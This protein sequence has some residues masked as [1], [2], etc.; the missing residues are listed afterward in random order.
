MFYK[1]IKRKQW[2]LIS[3]VF[4]LAV[5]ILSVDKSWRQEGNRNPY[6]TYSISNPVPLTQSSTEYWTKFLF[7]QQME[8]YDPNV[9]SQLILPAK[10]EFSTSTPQRRLAKV[11]IPGK[12]DALS[13]FCNWENS[14]S[15]LRTTETAVYDSHQAISR[16]SIELTRIEEAM[17]QPMFNN[18]VAVK[19]TG[20]KMM[21]NRRRRTSSVEGVYKRSAKNA[22]QTNRREKRIDAFSRCRKLIDEEQKSVQIKSNDATFVIDDESESETE[23]LDQ[24]YIERCELDA[25]QK[26]IDRMEISSLINLGDDFPINENDENTN[27]EQLCNTKMSEHPYEEANSKV[28]TME[29]QEN[30]SSNASDSVET[31]SSKFA[32]EENN[33]NSPFPSCSPNTAKMNGHCTHPMYLH[34]HK[35]PQIVRH[36]SLAR[37]NLNSEDNISRCWEFISAYNKM[38]P[39]MKIYLIGISAAL[40]GVLMHLF[41]WINCYQIIIHL[42]C[43]FHF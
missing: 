26:E 28:S 2:F 6:W 31:S 3:T 34:P 39:F 24:S 32:T 18:P 42:F 10:F 43:M 23:I 13:S 29:L 16:P 30:S 20:K 4:N 41:K 19:R 22:Q 5:N 17:L 37:I 12:F 15:F 25:F 7:L 33:N 9:L 21:N 27:F 11:S 14:L 38:H 35:I 1:T 8:N 40:V 36:K